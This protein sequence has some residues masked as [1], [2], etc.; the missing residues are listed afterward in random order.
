[1]ATISQMIFS[2]TFPWM[3]SFVF[4]FKF[5]LNLFLR[6]QLTST[7]LDNGSTPNW[8]QAIISRHYLNQSWLGPNSLAHICDTKGRWILR[9]SRQLVLYNN[10]ES[11][12]NLEFQVVVRNLE[13]DERSVNPA[14]IALWSSKT[15]AITYSH[16]KWVKQRRRT[17]I[18]FIRSI[19]F[20]KTSLF[21]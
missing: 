6:V 15:Y 7:G 5:Y 8:R 14:N 18:F 3:K 19:Y 11:Y 12:E 13:I 17:A 21:W 4:W 16:H 10:L 9:G 1:M 20:T 2:D